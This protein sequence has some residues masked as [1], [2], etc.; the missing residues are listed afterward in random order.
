MEYESTLTIVSR[1]VEDL[2]DAFKAVLER[3]S[4]VT[5]DAWRS[6]V[7]Y[8]PD[9]SCFIA[10]INRI[11]FWTPEDPEC[12]DTMEEIAGI[13]GEEGFAELVMR[14]SVSPDCHDYKVTTPDG[15]CISGF[16]DDNRGDEFKE[17]EDSYADDLIRFYSDGINGFEE[18]WTKDRQPE[19]P[20][21]SG[22]GSRRTSASSRNTCGRTRCTWNRTAPV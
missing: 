14:N 22:A 4:R 8:D 21:P 20:M 16:D 10:E 11:L 5:A 15:F 18:L 19:P 12:E 17:L 13:L 3:D 9:Q 7:S 6:A 1:S 2:R